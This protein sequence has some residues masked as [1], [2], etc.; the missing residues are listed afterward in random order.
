MAAPNPRSTDTDILLHTKL[1]PPHVLANALSRPRLWERLDAGVDGPLTVISAPAGYGKTTLVSSWLR[2][3]SSTPGVPFPAAWLSLD[4]RDSDLEVFMCYL[5]ASIDRTFPGVCPISL[6]MLTGPFTPPLLDLVST[7]S[8]ELE[9]LP[10]DFVLV[11]DDYHTLKGVAVGN[12]LAA[13]MRYWPLRLHLVLVTRHHLDLPLATLRAKGYLT[14]LTADDLRFTTGEVE[15]YLSQVVKVE[16]T[17]QLVEQIENQ[18]EGWAA[19]L[20]L[21]TIAMRRKGAVVRLSSRFDADHSLQEYLIEDVLGR[22]PA[23]V[24]DFLCRIAFLER[25][26]IDLCRAVTEPEVTEGQALAAL[27]WI[28]HTNF[29]IIP[30]DGNREWYRFHRLLR[31]ALRQFAAR[32]FTV[33]QI[34]EL[35]RRAARWFLAHNLIE[36]ALQQAMAIPDYPLAAEVVEAGFAAAL[37]REDRASLERWLRLFPDSFIEGHAGLLAIQTVVYQMVWHFG[38]MGRSLA[39]LNQLLETSPAPTTTLPPSLVNGIGHTVA[40]ILA[41]F[42]NQMGAAEEHARLALALLPTGMSYVRGGA[43]IFLGLSAQAAGRA[44]LAEAEILAEY[45]AL[46][47]AR[48]SYAVRLLMALVCIT[49]QEGRLDDAHRY[50]SLMRDKAELDGYSLMLGW[51]I[52]WLGLIHTEWDELDAAR[53]YFEAIVERRYTAHSQAARNGMIGLAFM[54]GMAGE[55]DASFHTLSLASQYDLNLIGDESPETRAL[56]AQLQS[57]HGDQAAARRW[58]ISLT[59]PAPDRP[60]VFFLEPHLVKIR[61]LISMDM[62]AEL[63]E[64]ALPIL[65]TMDDIARRT[66]NRRHQVHLE[67][68]R[69]IVLDMLGNGRGALPHIQRALELARP[70]G[71][72]RAFTSHGIRMQRLLAQLADAGGPQADDARRLLERFRSPA[73]PVLAAPV[74]DEPLTARELDVLQ[75]MRERLSD[76]EIAARLSISI[77]TVKRHSANLYG[78]LGVNRRWDAVSHAEELGILRRS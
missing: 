18:T 43:A 47:A 21:A 42:Q 23:E 45:E 3:R 22:E 40:S 14:E 35:H 24:S 6:A 11:L 56:R 48:T 41:Y 36:E 69:A 57:L 16:P 54:Q 4:E 70:G 65:D 71:F 62:T 44:T 37:N 64:Q 32:T 10:Q 67:A 74:L 38:N 8:N 9:Q 15:A 29:F 66:H 72:A 55:W 68:F 1:H 50:A 60:M 52:F 34:T 39:L 27:S 59:T 33:E 26:C 30:L 17:D 58:A 19:G 73:N 5:C 53:R 2:Y 25:W 63:R 13:L 78:K 20:N 28:E 75:L 77:G 76:K 49:L 12:L 46:P 7:L 51:A 61:L 31:D